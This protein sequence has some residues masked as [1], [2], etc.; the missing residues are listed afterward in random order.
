MPHVPGHPDESLF[1]R[2][3]QEQSEFVDGFLVPLNL[4]LRLLKHKLRGGKLVEVLS[5]SD[6]HPNHQRA[7]LQERVLRVAQHLLPLQMLR[8]LWKKNR[9]V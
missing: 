1:N 9:D 7:A 4:K 2:A 5:H 8:G 6:R 3:R